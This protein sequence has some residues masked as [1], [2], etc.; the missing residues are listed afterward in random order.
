MMLSWIERLYM[1]AVRAFPPDFHADFS[2]EM[3]DVFAERLRHQARRGVR[4]A[5]ALALQELWHFPAALLRAHIYRWGRRRR[6]WQR[7]LPSRPFHTPFGT[8]PFDEDG[9]F[10]RPHLLLE[11]LPFLFSSGLLLALTYAPAGWLPPGWRSPQ[12]TTAVW[13]GALPLV[14]LLAG[15]ARGLPRWAYP[16][17][18]LALGQTLFAAQQQRL[19]WFWAAMLLTAVLL[20]LMAAVVHR[21]ERPL[22]P[23]WRRA[24]AS[25]AL[26]WTRVSF[27][28][29]G[30]AP[31]LILAAFDNARSNAQTPYLG[32]AVLMMIGAALLYGRCRRQDRQLAVLLAGAALVLLPALLDQIYWQGGLSNW[33]AASGRVAADLGW[34]S[35]LWALITTLMLLPLLATL[36]PAAARAGHHS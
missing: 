10:S 3:A 5:L 30:A 32:T 9:R 25:M 31:L 29:F 8:P 12:Q 22:P 13:A 36:L 14:V 18:G 17:G 21:G 34:F 24:G 33:L 28:C 19:A 7:W 15:L 11:M 4:A 26:D 2:T 35:A 23:F 1:L 6:R 27:G 16:W 20:I